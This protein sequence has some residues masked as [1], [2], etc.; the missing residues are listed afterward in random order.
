[1]STVGSNSIYNTLV[2]D[3][4]STKSSSQTPD[5]KQLTTF[6]SDSKNPENQEL[7][8]GLFFELENDPEL[9]QIITKWSELPEHIKAAIRALIQTGG[10]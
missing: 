2:A 1:M 6:N 10:K 8:S 4:N 7:V 5:N 3:S 9:K